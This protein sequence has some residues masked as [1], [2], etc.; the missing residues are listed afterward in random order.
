LSHY[1]TAD[2]REETREA[3]IEDWLEDLLEFGPII[4]ADACATW[5]RSNRTRPTPSDIRKLAF[6]DQKERQAWGRS[7][8][9][10]LDGPLD[11]DA[12]ARALG[13]SSWLE[14][15]DAIRAQK[16][17]ELDGDW[18]HPERSRERTAPPAAGFKTLAEALGVK[19]TPMEDPND[20]DQ[21]E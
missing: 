20:A 8:L 2:D 6:E 9:N 3:Q 19:A 15:E 4:V 1:W 10:R 14:R 21:A 12:W 7:Q 16:Q 5:R 18:N 13:W 17:R 11:R